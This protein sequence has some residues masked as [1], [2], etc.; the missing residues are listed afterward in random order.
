[1]PL[2]GRKKWCSFSIKSSS[3]LLGTRAGIKS[4]WSSN[5]SWIGLLASQLSAIKCQNISSNGIFV[6]QKPVLVS[7]PVVSTVPSTVALSFEL[8]LYFELTVP[9][10]SDCC[11]LGRLVYKYAGQVLMISL[12][13]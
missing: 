11:P 5:F 4:Q 3:N 10:V 6:M 1:M 8:Y 9:Q 7:V 2:S 12:L 13:I